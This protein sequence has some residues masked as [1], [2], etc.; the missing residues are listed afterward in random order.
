MHF[1]GDELGLGLRY[2]RQRPT[3]MPVTLSRN[4]AV[5]KQAS[6]IAE[7]CLKVAGA[8]KPRNRAPWEP[9]RIEVCVG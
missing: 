1:G 8:F 7:R 6:T 9:S 5:G 4:D 2:E 3:P